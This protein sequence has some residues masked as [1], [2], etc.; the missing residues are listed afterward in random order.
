[1]LGLCSCQ[2]VYNV[3]VV[4]YARGETVLR[5]MVRL[6]VGYYDWIEKMRRSRLRQ[7]AICIVG[8]I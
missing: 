4:E 2:C 1:M 6:L 3:L 7:V 5:E 8:R